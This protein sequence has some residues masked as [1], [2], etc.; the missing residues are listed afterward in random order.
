VAADERK[1][2]DQKM[3]ETTFKTFT[4]KPDTIDEIKLL[5]C[6]PDSFAIEWKKPC[7][8]NVPITHFKVYLRT[9]EFDEYDLIG[10]LNVEEM[11]ESGNYCYE[12]TSLFASS[13]Y[14]VIVNAVNS[15]GEGYR[16]K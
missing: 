15:L 10:D 14:Y 12:V 8:N 2:Y 1:R 3:K 4:D 9:I 11:D 16:P 6:T 13:V 5:H 7:D